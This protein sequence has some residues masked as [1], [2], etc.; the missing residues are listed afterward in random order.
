LNF[1]GTIE[2]YKLLEKMNKI[3]NCKYSEMKH[4]ALGIG[5]SLQELNEKCKPSNL[6]V[7]D[8]VFE[9]KGVCVC[10]LGRASD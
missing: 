1:A 6:N 8:V 2:D 5:G 3:T 9:R 7:C 4:I 10:R